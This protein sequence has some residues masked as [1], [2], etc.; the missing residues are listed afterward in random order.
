M[1]S[2]VMD[3]NETVTGLNPML[4]RL[5]GEDV[6]LVV[7]VDPELGL[8]M[9]DAAQIEQVIMNLAVNARDAMPDG[10]TLTIST[11]NT[12]LDAGFARTHVG[13]V[14]GKYV[15]LMVADTGIGMAPEVMEHVFEPFFTTKERG[16][17]TGLGL[18]T[19]FAIARQFGGFVEVQSQPGVGSAF[20]FHLPRLQGA[21]RPAA[22]ADVTV[23]PLV[24]SETVL[25]AEDEAQVRQFVERVLS[26]AG[27]QVRVAANGAEAIDLASSLPRLDLLFTDVV[28][29][30]MSGVQL[31][32]HLAA[33]R[34]EL[35]V[36]YASGYSD[37]SVPH[38]TGDGPASS[39]LPK[40]FTADK[41][42]RQVRESLDRAATATAPA[43]SDKS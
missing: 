19:V 21:T 27:Y 16:K 41:L 3:I 4:S 23:R 7:H 30:G 22:T 15:V 32:A 42:L 20:S 25:V 14:E 38:G 9:A 10:G 2:R 6:Q 36:I 35:P 8:V 17:G 34:P 33:A 28:M 29:P 13:A 11:A 12:D 26:R 43:S 24:G 39:Y 18:A 31:A 40:P 5:I 37:E 1:D